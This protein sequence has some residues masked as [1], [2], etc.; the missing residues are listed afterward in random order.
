MQL[1]QKQRDNLWWKDGPHS[2]AKLTIDTNIISDKL[3]RIFIIVDIDINPL[4]FEI[5][6]KNRTYF[7]NDPVITEI[8]NSVHECKSSGYHWEVSRNLYESEADIQK[9]QCYLHQCQ[10]AIIRMHKFVMELLAP[11]K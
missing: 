3:S 4:T 2:L 5:I 9:G 1:T 7:K 10:E 8:L 6:S 11:I